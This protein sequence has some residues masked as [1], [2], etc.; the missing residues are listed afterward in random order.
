MTGNVH[1]LNRLINEN[2]LAVDSKL[3]WKV[4]TPI[5]GLFAAYRVGVIINGEDYSID[6]SAHWYGLR[7]HLSKALV[8]K[9]AALIA[10]GSGV[11]WVIAE[12]VALGIITSPAAIPFGLV[13]ALLALG[14]AALIL[15]DFCNGVDV[16]QPWTVP[17]I[18]IPVPG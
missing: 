15:L 4:I 17:P 5:T 9:L 3:G 18:F 13:A 1:E 8:Q 11:S 14:A 16:I 2:L 6:V 7:W 12:L 10:V